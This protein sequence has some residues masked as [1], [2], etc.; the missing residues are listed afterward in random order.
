[1]YSLNWKM[2]QCRKP[3]PMR[4]Q[5]ILRLAF[6]SA[7]LA[8][9]LLFWLCELDVFD[10]LSGWNFFAAP[11][12]WHVLWGI[13]VLSMLTQLIPLPH[14]VP[15]GS[16]KLFRQRFQSAGQWDAQAL[17]TYLREKNRRALLTMAL[18]CAMLAIVGALRLCGVLTDR[19]LLMLT[20]L[21][22]VGDLVCVLVFCPFRLLMGSRCC[23]VCR[24]YN[25]DHFFMFSPLLF[26]RGF[27][28]LSLAA[29]SV[30]TIVVWEAVLLRHPERFWEG[31]NRALRCGACTDKL[32][33][34]FCPRK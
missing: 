27:F 3:S 16:Q 11:S 7:V 5:Y 17:H 4:L 6:R 25:W 26:S 30:V 8:A 1:M 20:L 18:W 15:L 22:Y 13:W 24:I 29:L 10:I 2:R 14:G 12:L 9:G 28:G 33:A 32:C 21:F 31:S 34:Q 23:T 19:E